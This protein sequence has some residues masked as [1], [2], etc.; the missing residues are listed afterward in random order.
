MISVFIIW[1][2]KST[3]CN[4]GNDEK[5]L[6]KGEIKKSSPIGELLMLGLVSRSFLDA[7]GLARFYRSRSSGA[8]GS[9][10]LLRSCIST[11]RT[12]KSCAD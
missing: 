5:V 9:F 7:A 8:C 12:E 4:F 6:E 1:S 11:D 10:F 3:G 2:S